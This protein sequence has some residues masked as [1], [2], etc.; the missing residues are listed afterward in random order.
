[1]VC[2]FFLLTIFNAKR[3]RRNCKGIVLDFIALSVDKAEKDISASDTDKLDAVFFIP[4]IDRKAVI[5]A[6][7]FADPP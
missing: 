6:F 2:F 7:G 4:A 3:R 5:C 1:A